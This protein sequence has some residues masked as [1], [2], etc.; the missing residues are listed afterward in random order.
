MNLAEQMGE[1][2]DYQPYALTPFFE[3]I[4]QVLLQT[5]ERPD[6]DESNLR[7]AAYETLSSLVQN[8]SSV[9]AYFLIVKISLYSLYL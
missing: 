9:R 8:S 1:D 2:S 5:T 6:G 4:V 7:T 3:A